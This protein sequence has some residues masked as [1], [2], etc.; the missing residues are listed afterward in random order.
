MAS[1]VLNFDLRRF[2]D[3]RPGEAARISLMAALLFFLLAANN[4]IKIVRDSLF[5]SRFPITQLPY[6]YL[7]AA[8]IA[9]V[10]IVVYSRYA[11]RLPFAQVVLGS[12]GVVVSNVFVFWLLVTFYDAAW[13]LYAYY[14]WSAIIG[15]VLVAQFWTLAN[16]MFTPRDG[17]RLFGIIT[18]GGTL[19]AMLGG[20][21][22]N[23]A[24]GFLFGAKHL[25]WLIAALLGAAYGVAYLALRKREALA[26][27]R[28]AAARGMATED[29]RGVVGTV[30]DSRYLQTI[31]A[32]IFLSVVVSTLIDY[33][34]KATAKEA[35]P[36][37][38]ALAGFFGSYYGWLSVVTMAAQLWL[39]GKVLLGLGLTPSLAI[40]PVALLGGSISLLAW[41]GLFAATATRMAEAALRT[42]IHQSGVQILYLPVPDSIKKKAKVFMDVT[43]ERLGDGAAAILILFLSLVL[44]Q[45]EVTLLSYFSVG[46]IAIW[47]AVVLNAH[48]GYLDTLRRSLAHH[49]LSL[50]AAQINFADTATVEA[51]LEGLDGMDEQSI[52]FALDL[53]EK[54]D[55]QRVAAQL[56]RTLLSHPSPEVRRRALTLVASSL[57]SN[58]LAMVFELLVSDRAQ[59]RGE[60]INTLATVLKRADILAVRPLLQSPERQ[61]RRAAI[62][63]MF[64]SG[65]APARQEA[66]T[67]FRELVMDFGPEGEKSRVEAARLMGEL[68][69]P[70]FA[71][72]LCRLIKDDPSPAVI[73]ESMSAAALGKYP[74]VIPE[75]ISRLSDGATKAEARE[76]LIQY[77]E[78]AVKGL[79]SALADGRVARDIRLYI[80]KTLSK[81]HAQAAMN[82]L[83]GG[84]LDE[85]RAIRFE[86]ILALKEMARRFEDLKI[87]RQIIE[88]AI[89]SDAQLYFRRF[90]MCFALFNE[91]TA[92]THQDSLLYHALVES[93][94]RVK[95]RVMWLLSLI[96]SGKDI[97]PVWSGLNS[98]DPL[99]RAHATE[100][101]D[102]LLTGHLKNYVFPLYDDGQP[103]QRLRMALN[104]LGMEFIDTNSALR[105]LLAQDDRWLK[106]A[107]VWEIG[108][109][110][111]SGYRD[112]LSKLAGADDPMLRET[113][114]IVIERIQPS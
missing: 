51:I 83:H 86:V 73:R 39:S 20:F 71:D 47:I 63:L 12:L 41:P 15:L 52:L 37:A 4:V 103:D 95:E 69:E 80:P 91:K 98:K 31:A 36:S 3:V 59:S 84:L 43:V 44:G 16:E 87:D 25:L 81:I 49:E 111:L 7:L 21:M 57:D 101:L 5:L 46:L 62:R 96:Y 64:Q 8:L 35:Y 38:D 90:V 17:K 88:S 60:A 2:L 113:A 68:A 92:L 24:V 50:D 76:A 42:S 97:R 109:R 9:A 102:N 66:L 75:V 112:L 99:Q 28:E 85:D 104:S 89:M 54:M 48:K 19:G 107:T 110:K 22:A 100:L 74:A 40:L 29:M 32:V 45:G 56:P 79:R 93:M 70:L 26:A 6:V 11:S 78:M 94:E 30:L 18:A 23:W 13:V 34:F 27:G 10:V 72:P 108:L 82:A 105:A 65:D 58:V 67:A 55:A 14:M 33:Q 53:A 114:N 106:A 77:G 61:T 1:G